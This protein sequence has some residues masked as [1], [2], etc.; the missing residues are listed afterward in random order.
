[1]YAF[2]YDHKII[3]EE[4]V[5]GREIECA[6]LGNDDPIASIPGEVIPKDGFYSYEAKYVDENGATLKIPAD[7]TEDQIT[8]IKDL[9]LE[10]FILCECTGMARVDMFLTPD[11]RLIINEINTIPGFTDISMYPTLWE[12][13]GISNQELVDRLITLAIEAHEVDSQLKR[14][15]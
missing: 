6:V 14:I 15:N 2:E 1:M 12:I 9:A 10:T 13:S 8:H 5:S 11:D 7:L 4:R 3:I